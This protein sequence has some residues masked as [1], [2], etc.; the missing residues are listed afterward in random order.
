MALSDPLGDML[1][2]IRN[3]QM[4][5]LSVVVCPWS[6]LREAVLVALKAEGYIR[7]FVKK[8]LPGNKAVLEIQLKYTDGAGAI[9]QI[10][11]VSKPGRRVYKK[12]KDMPRFYN[13]LGVLLV[14][15]PRGILT[16]RA[17][18]EA[19]VG[20]EVLCRVY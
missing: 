7:G 20:G 3:G 5:R 10:D 2:R 19:N 12:V 1:T 6:T 18:R 16:D 14:S 8:D 9:R 15:T 11:R 17:A 4:A 13:G